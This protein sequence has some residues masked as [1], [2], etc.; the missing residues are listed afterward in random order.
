MPRFDDKHVMVTGC[1]VVWDGVTRPET[2]PQTGKIKYTL[3]VV[4][5]P[6]SPDLALYQVLA[7][8]TL[9]ASKF[10]G[11]L[12]AGGL[13]PIGQTK[14]GEFNNLFPGYAVISGKTFFAPDVFDE[15]GAKMDPMQY[16]PSIYPGQR[17]DIL[18]H[19]Y[20]YDKMGN[21]GVAAGLDGLRIV[22][23]AAAPKLDIGTGGVDTAA[24]FGAPAAYQA[25]TAGAPAP[26]PAPVPAAGGFDP[27]TGQPI[28][29]VQPVQASNF[30]PPGAPA[31]VPGARTILGYDPTT[32]QPIYSQ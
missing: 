30:L 17:V 24:A 18:L 10:R 1:T 6:Q 3:K 28:A 13:M 7:Q 11:V 19:C 23:S 32:G 16:A 8:E 12:P 20:D 26:A 22:A 25:P 14:P 5:P 4:V 21:Q 15:T 2:D 27:V 9:Q 31:P 29:P